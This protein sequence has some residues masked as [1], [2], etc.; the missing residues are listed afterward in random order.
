MML[1]DCYYFDDSDIV[2]TDGR[3]RKPNHNTT[4]GAWGMG[5]VSSSPLF[6]NTPPF[7][8]FT[9]KSF[10]LSIYKYTVYIMF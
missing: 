7:S 10:L 8:K 6:S 1:Y 9:Y 2:F 3:Q 4:T 5:F